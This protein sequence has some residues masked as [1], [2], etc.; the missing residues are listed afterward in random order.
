MSNPYIAA[1]REWDERF[2]FHAKQAKIAFIAAIALGLVCLT[3]GGVIVWQSIHRQ[4]IPY[5]VMVDD[6]GRPLLA[7]PPQVLTDWPEAVVLREVSDIVERLRSIPSDKAVLD[8]AWRKLVLFSLPGTAG[9][10]KLTERAKSQ[11]LS[12]FLLQE[13]ITIAVE[14]RSVL[15]QGGSTWIAEWSETTRERSTGSLIEVKRYQGSFQLSQLGN[16]EPE[17]L[18]INPLG[19]LLQDYD[20]RLLGAE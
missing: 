5:V 10:Q 1:Q 4:Y 15:F 12:P 18:T 7:Q 19:I 8:T 11:T 17:V 6:L 14:I 16:L 13:Q 3:L 20:I 2:A 9:Y